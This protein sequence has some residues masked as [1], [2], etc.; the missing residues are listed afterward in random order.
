MIPIQIRPG[1]F[2]LDDTRPVNHQYRKMRIWKTNQHFHEALFYQYC[3]ARHKITNLLLILKCLYSFAVFYY[4]M[5]EKSDTRQWQWLLATFTFKIQPKS[6]RDR[7]I[8]LIQL[9][10]TSPDFASYSLNSI[11]RFVNIISGK[12][13]SF[14]STQIEFNDNLQGLKERKAIPVNL[15]SICSL[16]RN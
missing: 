6:F 13:R 10:R 15:S 11:N 8:G 9:R 12:L 14:M 3:E 4:T 16:L 7:L 2:Q 5:I 1:S